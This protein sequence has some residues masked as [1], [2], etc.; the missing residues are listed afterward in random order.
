MHI[1]ITRLRCQAAD[2]H[3]QRR[4]SGNCQLSGDSVFGCGL[5]HPPTFLLPPP[6]P[7]PPKPQPAQPPTSSSTATATLA[8]AAT[9]TDA[10][11]AAA[12]PTS[13]RLGSRRGR[14]AAAALAAAQ[15]HRRLPGDCDRG[16][17]TTVALTTG[18]AVDVG[19]RGHRSRARQTSNG[20]QTRERSMTT[21][22]HGCLNDIL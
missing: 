16:P 7:T 1:N 17:V 9:T 5:L 13:H 6:P 2:R 14:T 22:E 18:T 8:A 11:P 15:S 12:A 10:S 4:L 3:G 20:Q 19:G 21:S